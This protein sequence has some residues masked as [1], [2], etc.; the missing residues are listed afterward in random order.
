MS[1][2][3]ATPEAVDGIGGQPPDNQDDENQEQTYLK[4]ILTAVGFTM[5]G[6]ALMTVYGVLFN[7]IYYLMSGGATN[8]TEWATAN[9]PEMLIIEIVASL[10]GMTTLAIILAT[11]TDRGWEFFD[12][13]KPNLPEIGLIF[14]SAIGLL[15]LSNATTALFGWL[16][17]NQSQHA[18]VNLAESGRVDPAF[19]LLFIPL[20]L[21][22]IGPS[23]ELLFR[24]I[25]QKSLYKRFTKRQA[26]L[27]AG[28]LFASIH[29][30]VYSTVGAG[31][32][33]A[34]LSNV[35]MLGSILGLTYA[36]SDKL[37]VPA[38]AHGV[39]NA[40]LFGLLYL[41]LSGFL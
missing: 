6:L 39:Y 20:S 18:I 24:N 13:D 1:N 25:V 26:A 30:P 8:I 31:S 15:I 35:F 32:A 28:L 22:F 41:D 11:H 37:V 2:Q 33:F 27:V 38:A 12:L 34:S 23:E 4:T 14:G 10:C 16:G 17:V 29:I 9:R 40:A 5:S 19:F 7:A 21:L 3:Q 36:Y